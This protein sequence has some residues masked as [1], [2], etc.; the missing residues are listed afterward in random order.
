M[1]TRAFGAGDDHPLHNEAEVRKMIAG[2]PADPAA[3][4]AELVHW[5]VSTNAHERYSPEHRA[6]SLAA[7]DA[8][9][10]ERWPAV[11]GAC[12][13]PGGKPAEG[14]DLDNATIR[15]LLE[16][17]TAF[18]NGHKASLAGSASEGGWIRRNIAPLTLR[19]AVWLARRLT[20]ANMMH[21]PN[22]AS[23]WEEAHV[24]YKQAGVQQVLAAAQQLSADAP[25]T[26]VKQEYVRMLM[27]DIA[28]QDTMNAREIELAFRI[29]GRVAASARLEL[30]PILGALYVVVPQGALRPMPVRRLASGPALFLDARPCALALQATLLSD[31]GRRSARPDV[32]F[33]GHFTE[34]ETFDMAQ[35]L[36]DYWGPTPPKRRSQRVALDAQASLRCGL[37][38]AVE[39]ITALEQGV[40]LR[41]AAAGA[42]FIEYEATRSVSN[43]GMKAV[44][45]TKARL[46][47]ASAA[48][49]G[50]LAPRK[51]ADWIRVG[52]LLA[53]LVEPGPDWVVG[54]LCRISAESSA[55]GEMLRFGI[56]VLARRPKA[57]WFHVPPEARAPDAPQEGWSERNFLAYFKRGILLDV[58]LAPGVTGEMLVPHGA[59]KAG[60]VLDVPG[61]I[62]TQHARVTALRESTPGYDRVAFEVLPPTVHK[63]SAGPESD[64]PDPWKFA[65]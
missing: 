26:S 1:I 62:A 22:I 2:L 21:Q 27:M 43:R 28:G 49:L 63:T 19:R 6:R 13:A 30:E 7:M 4:L 8:A 46:A 40:T 44:R 24:L 45:E 5:A 15:S 35:R 41:Q 3:A 39:S 52:T 47:D 20:L 58:E 33:G 50:L 25:L 42:A 60:Q 9:A 64:A 37:D 29:A 55:T 54:T 57:C 18:A 32:L 11:C 34:R 14:R 48:G 65:A 36:A 56:R 23:M 59:A 17:A 31:A 38:N 10:H 16:I 12:L 61:E 53:L 51:D